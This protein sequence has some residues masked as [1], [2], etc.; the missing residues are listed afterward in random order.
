MSGRQT[1]ASA[2]ARCQTQLMRPVFYDGSVSGQAWDPLEWFAFGSFGPV[3]S[4]TTPDP[5]L[6]AA[7]FVRVLAVRYAQRLSIS[8]HIGC[9]SIKIIYI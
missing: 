9:V 8:Q 4:S 5:R 2:V 3:S 7:G 6:D 1:S